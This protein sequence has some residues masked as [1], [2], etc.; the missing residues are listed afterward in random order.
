MTRYQQIINMSID[1][2]AEFFTLNADCFACEYEACCK[3]TDRCIDG[4]KEWL[5]KGVKDEI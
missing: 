2:L 3:S 4:H 1:E 5:M